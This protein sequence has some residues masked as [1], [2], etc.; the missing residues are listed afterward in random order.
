MPPDNQARIEHMLEADRRV[1]SAT[2]PLTRESKRFGV[3]VQRAADG[4]L[5]ATWRR[6]QDQSQDQD[7]DQNQDQSN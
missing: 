2:D 5:H 3:R 4:M 7:Q 1:R 6:G